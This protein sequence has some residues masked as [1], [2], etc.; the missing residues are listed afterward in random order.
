[1]QQ[2]GHQ[3]VGQLLLLGVV[4]QVHQG[5]LLLLLAHSILVLLRKLIAKDLGEV[6]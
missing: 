1:M 6:S 4:V 2:V 3:T 5:A